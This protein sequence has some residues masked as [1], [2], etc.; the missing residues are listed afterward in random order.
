MQEMKSPKK[1]LIYYCLIGLTL[2]LLL[3]IFFFPNVLRR[4]VQE[5]G[6]DTFMDM[7]ENGEIGTVEIESNQILFTDKDNTT[8][9]K[10]GII[11]D[12]N[13]VER[14]YNSGA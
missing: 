6:Y 7:T 3:N 13:L 9:Y 14:L 1:P 10:T 2:Y 5:V 8:Y 4:T 11:D 12:P